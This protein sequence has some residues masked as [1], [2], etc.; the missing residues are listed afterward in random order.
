MLCPFTG[1]SAAAATLLYPRS[2]HFRPFQGSVADILGRLDA[3][4][5][6]ATHT[7]DEPP[8]MRFD[9]RWQVL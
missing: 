7:I 1:S 4:S 5:K 2:F 9:C 8:C 3:A 6:F